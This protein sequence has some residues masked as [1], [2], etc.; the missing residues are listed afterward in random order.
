MAGRL[1][2]PAAWLATLALALAAA[3]SA[4]A[5]TSHGAADPLA[6]DSTL[7]HTITGDDPKQ[8]FKFLRL[9]P[10]EPYA[11]RTDLAAPR[12]GR[13]GRRRSLAYF[14]QIT[15]F[16][17]ADEES[18]AR[19]EFLDVDPSNT[20]NAAYRAQEA[21]IPHLTDWSIR[22]MNAFTTSPIA[23]G[24]GE[25]ASMLAAMMTGDLADNQQRN[26]TEW[27]RTLLEGGLLD[28]NSGTSDLSG[29]SCP[30]GTPLD[31]PRNYTGVQDH[32]DTPT[33]D[34][35]YYDPD[36]PSGEAAG[37]PKYA[38][39]LDQ[40]QKPFMAEGLRVPSYVLFGNHDGLVQGNQSATAP[41]ERIAT[42]CVKPLAATGIAT[43]FEP[44]VLTP[45][46]SV[47]L[48]P[49]DQRRQ[50]V[51]KLQFK[52]IFDTPAQA[53]D[54]GFA[55][56]DRAELDASG[57]AAGYY[58]W[59]PRPG[60]RFVALDTLSEGGVTPTS[61]NGNVDE[62]QFNW[63]EGVL[64]KATA[65]DEIV[66]VFAHHARSSLTA[67]VPDEATGECPPDDEHGHSA[68]PGCDRDPRPSNPKLGDDVAAL[69]H[70][71]PNA[72]AYVAGHSHENRV[73]PQKSEDGKAGY[74]ELKSPALADWPPQD[75]VVEVMDNCDGTLSIFGTILDTANR[76]E[77][78]APG[79]AAGGF[80]SQTLASIARTL[81]YNDPQLGPGSGAQGK[82]IDRNV[83]LLVRDPR[84]FPPACAGANTGGA[85]GGTGGGGTK[86]GAKPKIKLSVKPRTVRGGRRTCFRFKA[87][88]AGRVVPGATIG[89]AG[90]RGTT[91][92]KGTKK[93]CLRIYRSKPVY[94]KRKGFQTGRSTI[95]VLRRKR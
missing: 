33:D 18:P 82:E 14:G 81:T 20:A 72:V 46:A 16:Q 43:A 63:F 78:P 51:D 59:S 85:G 86:A 92:R 45:P 25:R 79:T 83:E 52:K 22:Q 10:G 30:P 75:R 64:R 40:A 76:V 50:F 69:M 80:D 66:V 38:G 61:S 90:R 7:D 73:A 87:T 11:V 58:E 5:H 39:L 36:D 23:Q 48:V 93:V 47:M 4:T 60:L 74:W 70:R 19:V 56:V 54:H 26:E 28:P 35:H 27:V 84:R 62:P 13:A 65:R 17:L 24:N 77:A 55:L 94:A 41:I 42:G 29:T 44:T 21:L 68:N 34:P 1:R 8:G 91:G 15:D 31:D 12:D 53:D 32:D 37:W 3:T 9:G 88:S 6:G 49:P 67:D 57:G 95:R 2:R 89:F 71:Y